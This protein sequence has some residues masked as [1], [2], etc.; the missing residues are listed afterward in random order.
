MLVI[1]HILT[2]PLSPR[3]LTSFKT[4]ALTRTKKERDPVLAKG[5]DTMTVKQ[6][7]RLITVLREL[8]V[9]DSIII[10]ILLRLA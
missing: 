2:S 8:S 5:G 7:T 9:P 6:I 10:Y 3:T 4:Y 1:F